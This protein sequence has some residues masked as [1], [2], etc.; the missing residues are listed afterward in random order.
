MTKFDGY[1][2][3]VLSSGSTAVLRTHNNGNTWEYVGGLATLNLKG[4]GQVRDWTVLDD[5]L[6]VGCSRGF[7]RWNEAE[8]AW[9]DFSRGASAPVQVPYTSTPRNTSAGC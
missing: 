4:F 5:Q 8:Q 3:A 9:E 6:Y 2:W 7:A 1:W